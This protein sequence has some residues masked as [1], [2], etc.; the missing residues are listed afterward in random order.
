MSTEF[1]LYLAIIVFTLLVIGLALSAKEFNRLTKD[2]SIQ[3]GL[4]DDQKSDRQ[5]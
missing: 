5:E 2:P 3:K 1:I 4:G